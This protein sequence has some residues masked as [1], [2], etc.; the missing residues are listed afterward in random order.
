MFITHTDITHPH[1]EVS[2][3]LQVVLEVC[4]YVELQKQIHSIVYS[5]SLYKKIQKL[6]KAEESIFSTVLERQMLVFYFICQN[7]F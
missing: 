7:T 1:L 3:N 6:I 5:Y 4:L 2:H